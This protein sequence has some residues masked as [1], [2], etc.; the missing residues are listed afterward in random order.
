MFK[1]WKKP[2]KIALLLLNVLT[3]KILYFYL[4]R[5]PWKRSGEMT[6]LGAPPDMK[7]LSLHTQF[8]SP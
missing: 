5:D 4:R 3:W 8:I 1:V 6:Y 7:P 2:Q